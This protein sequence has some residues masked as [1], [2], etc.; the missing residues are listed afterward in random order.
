MMKMKKEEKQE[1]KEIPKESG[2]IKFEISKTEEAMHQVID[3]EEEEEEVEMQ[4]CPCC[5]GDRSSW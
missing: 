3:H 4:V 2:K 1:T 5:N